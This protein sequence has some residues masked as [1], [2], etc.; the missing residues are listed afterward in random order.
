ME[1][2]R[3]EAAI[4]RKMPRRDWLEKDQLES[5]ISAQSLSFTRIRFVGRGWG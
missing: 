2:A 5:V 3:K 1:R 4:D